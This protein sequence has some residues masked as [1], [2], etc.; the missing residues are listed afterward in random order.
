MI[1]IKKHYI[2]ISIFILF[3]VFL[4][5]FLWRIGVEESGKK[6]LPEEEI[7]TSLS[8]SEAGE[9][10]DIK[11]K[12]EMTGDEKSLVAPVMPSAIF[13]T[14]GVIFERN[15]NSLIVVGKGTNFA[16]GISRKLVCTFTDETLTFG[17][18]QLKYYQGIEG[19]KYLKEG[20]EILV[21]S[22][23]N[24]RGKTEFEVKSVNILK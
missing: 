13:S 23:E 17:K 3:I 1:L 16:D 18:D 9:I 4:T 12:D 15:D 22:D 6:Y 19:L 2:F 11:I 7:I 20:M 10:G 14:T 21:D 5:Y 8:K 24:I